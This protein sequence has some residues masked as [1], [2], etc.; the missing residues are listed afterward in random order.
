[1]PVS[2]WRQ[3]ERCLLWCVCTLRFVA[4]GKMTELIV[5]VPLIVAVVFALGCL[6]APRPATGDR[7]S[8]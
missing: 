3:P 7:L 1:M 6:L 5:Y 4:G 2:I 8:G